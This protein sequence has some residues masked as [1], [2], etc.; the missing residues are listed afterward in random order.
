MPVAALSKINHDGP[1]I[2][3]RARFEMFVSRRA[4]RG[5]PA[6]RKACQAALA[7]QEIMDE[8]CEK[9]HKQF[10]SERAGPLMDFLTWLMDHADQ[11]IAFI[12]KILPLF[13]V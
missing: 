6:E 3:E 5:T 2:W 11:I 4:R 1:T 12:M 9:L 10:R 7:N 8:A 13:I